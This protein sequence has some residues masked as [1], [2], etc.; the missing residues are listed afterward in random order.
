MAKGKK[1][2]KPSIDNWEALA[3]RSTIFYSASEELDL[4][5]LNWWEKVAGQ[6][7]ENSTTKPIEGILLENC[8][9]SNGFLTLKIEP[10]LQS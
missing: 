10:P 4:S 5:T 2:E 1:Q 3:L 9:F 8:E 7:P 6:A